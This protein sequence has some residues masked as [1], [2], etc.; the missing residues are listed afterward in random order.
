MTHENLINSIRTIVCPPNWALCRKLI[1]P[2]AY[3][4]ELNEG[5]VAN[6]LV[7]NTAKS[8]LSR[9]E[10]WLETETQRIPAADWE[11]LMGSYPR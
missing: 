7:M 8:M 1:G 11:Q 5:T 3:A 6:S 9:T 4:W 2:I 10:V